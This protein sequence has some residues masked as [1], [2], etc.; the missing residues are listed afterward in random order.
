MNQWNWFALLKTYEK[1]KIVNDAIDLD[2]SFLGVVLKTIDELSRLKDQKNVTKISY[3]WSNVN[4]F[5][6]L[7]S[8]TDLAEEH[9]D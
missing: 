6:A 2:A 4:T 3:Y 9:N 8:K 7:S 5:I 1:F